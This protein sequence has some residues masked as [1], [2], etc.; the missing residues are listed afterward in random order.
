MLANMRNVTRSPLGTPAMY[1]SMVSSR[2]SWPSWA[3]CRI[4]V[5]VNVLVIE[6]MRVCMPAAIG[7]VLAGSAMP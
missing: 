5:T 2:E 1:S 6:P 3:S 4:A 7:V